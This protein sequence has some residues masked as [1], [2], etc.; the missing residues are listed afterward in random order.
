MLNKIAA[1]VIAVTVLIFA[2]LLYFARPQSPDTNRLSEISAQI[3][4]LDR[5]KTE[6]QA[7]MTELE[8]NYRITVQDVATEQFVFTDLIDRVYSE[9]YPIMRAYSAT[10]VL[11][12]SKAYFDEP[13]GALTEEQFSA[14]LKAGWSYCLYYTGAPGAAS[15]E[16]TPEDRFT[17]WLDSMKTLLET[18]ELSLPDTVY[19]APGT[20]N[21]AFDSVL[22]MNDISIAVHH[23]EGELPLMVNN[24]GGGIWRIGAQPWN[25][26]TIRTVL[27]NLVLRNANLVFDV[28]FEE[29]SDA[30]FDSYG[31][32]QML[33]YIAT[34]RVEERL[35]V[36]DFGTAYA[37]K[38]ETERLI[39]LYHSDYTAN[40]D[41][42]QKQIDDIEAQVKELS[43]NYQ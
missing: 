15:A 31:F 26:D 5:E 13:T 18:R 23:G 17:A 35:E 28:N 25:G 32:R 4:R 27:D 37:R 10:G 11:A 36:T 29:N 43:A 30:V 33:D 21:T 40:H 24:T 16:E 8:K 1:V 39:N 20:Y 3:E 34:F 12:V 38:R 14:L 42:L 22:S 9:A 19:F 7:Q 6:L 41:D 2:G